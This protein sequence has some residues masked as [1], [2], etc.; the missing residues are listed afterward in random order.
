MAVETSGVLG[1]EALQLLR[2]LGHRLREATGEQIKV[3][4]VSP[5]ASVRGRAAGE[6]GGCCGISRGIFGL[7]VGGVLT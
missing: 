5:P 1:P 2:D 6:Q 7:G 3:L 4:S